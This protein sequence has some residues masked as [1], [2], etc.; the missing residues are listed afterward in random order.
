LLQSAARFK[1]DY[2][3]LM[4]SNNQTISQQQQ[5][6]QQQQQ[7]LHML[8]PNTTNVLVTDTSDSLVARAREL[9]TM[10][11]TGESNNDLIERQLSDTGIPAYADW[12]AEYL[13]RSSHPEYWSPDA[14]PHN[15]AMLVNEVPNTVSD[16]L[17]RELLSAME[18]TTTDII[19]FRGDGDLQ[20]HPLVELHVGNVLPIESFL[21]T[22]TF[23]ETA[24][25]FIDYTAYHDGSSITY[26]RRLL[27]VHISTGTEVV[28]V[29]KYQPENY[30]GELILYKGWLEILDC[31]S[32]TKRL[33]PNLT[34]TYKHYRCRYFTNIPGQDQ[35]Q[36]QEHEYNDLL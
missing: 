18:P 20:F 23:K 27:E 17:T 21:S 9:A 34:I 19:V 26:Q 3:E 30:E 36:D 29:D 10:L 1:A 5:Q 24:E 14:P 25:S 12:F 4:L 8:S 15:M 31:Q 16:R 28:D 11:L 32:V 22:S 35:G 7:P 13:I 6:Q 2:A 33:R